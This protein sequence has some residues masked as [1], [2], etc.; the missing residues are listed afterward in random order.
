MMFSQ[1]NILE[2]TP[3][4]ALDD[5]QTQV[6]HCTDYVA[7]IFTDESQAIDYQR[8]VQSCPVPCIGMAFVSSKR[9]RLKQRFIAS[10]E[11]SRCYACPCR[12]ARSPEEAR[13]WLEY[14]LTSAL[15]L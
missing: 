5:L 1:L 15:S 9:M 3:D 11:L 7:F 13:L 2:V 12:L 6:S 8:L 4:T 14:R 10:I